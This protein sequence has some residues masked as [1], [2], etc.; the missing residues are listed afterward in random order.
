[1]FEAA[2]GAQDKFSSFVLVGTH[3]PPFLFH[4]AQLLCLAHVGYIQRL[5]TAVE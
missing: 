1:M 5:K 4:E 3:A 2:L